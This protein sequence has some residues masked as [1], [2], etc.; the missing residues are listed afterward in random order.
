MN[1]LRDHLQAITPPQQKLCL[2]L[3]TFLIPCFQVAWLVQNRNTKL[4][5]NMCLESTNTLMSHLSLVDS[6]R[7]SLQFCIPILDQ[8]SNLKNTVYS[9]NE[10]CVPQTCIS[11]TPLLKQAIDLKRRDMSR[12]DLALAQESCR[13]HGTFSL[14]PT[15]NVCITHHVLSIA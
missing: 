15:A 13:G 9:T 7:D 4:Q 11:R 6:S 1:H 12:H 3:T 14:L 8:A 2:C 5:T 10:T